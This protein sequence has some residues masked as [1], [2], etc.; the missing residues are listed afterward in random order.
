MAVVLSGLTILGVAPGPS[1]LTAHLDEVFAG[2]FT[3]GFA[4]LLGSVLGLFMAPYLAKALR[5]PPYAIVPFIFALSLLGAAAS[6]YNFTMAVVAIGFGL[7]GLIMKRYRYSP[8]ATMIGFVLGPIIEKNLYLTTRLQGMS[9]FARPLT[10]VFAAIVIIMIAS[11]AV[12]PIWR[13]V[14][15]GRSW[16]KAETTVSNSTKPAEGRVLETSRIELSVDLAWVV[17]AAAY[18]AIASTFPPDGR[19]MPLA[20]GAGALV[21]GLVHLGGNFIPLMRPFTHGERDAQ[22]GSAGAE[23]G[24]IDPSQ[25]K[26]IAWAISLLVAIFMIGALPAIFL[27]FLAY[28][29]IGARRWVLAPVSAVLMTLLT[30]GV[31][32]QLMSLQLPQGVIAQLFLNTI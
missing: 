17:V 9:A 31:F 32:G 25:L 23:G 4:S 7:I 3:I 26:A 2:A 20:V 11:P 30:W 6:S 28:F 16:Q 15:T 22:A 12:V 5:A 10:D 1:M 14:A 27:F 24:Q 18:C 8:A 19:L 13:R 29:G 21:L